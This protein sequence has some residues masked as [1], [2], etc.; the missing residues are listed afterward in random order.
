MQKPLKLNR[1][2]VK[3]LIEYL[4]TGTMQAVERSVAEGTINFSKFHSSKIAKASIKHLSKMKV[5]NVEIFAD[6][7]RMYDIF[8]KWILFAILLSSES[9]MAGQVGSKFEDVSKR[10]ASAR[11]FR[12]PV[13]T[14]GKHSLKRINDRL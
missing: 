7:W 14:L 12:R 2:F 5:K 11:M 6:V 4:V 10:F 1:S 8:R 9:L 3:D 13:L